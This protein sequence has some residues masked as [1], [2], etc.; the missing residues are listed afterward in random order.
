M[1]EDSG[2]KTEE[3]T[4]HKIREA[5]KKGQIAK[6]QEITSA[7]ML[8][9]SFYTF[10]MVG[11]MM[12]D[13]ISNHTTLVLSLLDL[14]FSSALVSMLLMDALKTILL[15]LAPLIGVVFVMVIIVE[16]LQTGFLFSL[17]ALSPKFDNLNPI[18]GFK[19]FF[20]LKQYIEL[21]KSIIKM[22]AVGTILFYTIKEL[23]PLV[24]QSQQQSPISLIALVGKIIIDTITRV[25]IVYF[26]LAILDYFYQKYEYI[27]SLKMS[28]KEIKEEYKRLEGD[29]II[30]Q[31]QREAQRAMS[32]GRQMGQVPGADVVVTNPVHIAVAVKYDP[33][34]KDAIPIVVAK[35]QRLVAEQIKQIA[36]EH[37]IPIIENPPVARLLFKL[38]DIGHYIP[39]EAFKV[40]AEILAFVFHI[41]NKKNT[42][43]AAKEAIKFDR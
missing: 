5:R 27:K 17:E 37:D 39:Q 10:K 24:S 19:K 33:E 4:P 1:G 25:G 15:G 23:Y 20:A 22:A 40:V 29:P 31:R 43:Q 38:V 8:L 35:G 21:I 28:K 30:K 7:I 41:N 11:P 9:V 18:N 3:P 26:A 36:D 34:K 6:S 12:M 13:R 32:Q 14:E 2:D 42:N 16:S